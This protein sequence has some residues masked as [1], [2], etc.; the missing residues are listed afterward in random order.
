MNT[1][2]KS[3][4]AETVPQESFSSLH[5][6]ISRRVGNI[7]AATLDGRGMNSD[8]AIGMAKAIQE[9]IDYAFGKN[10]PRTMQGESH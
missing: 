6:D 5:G 10:A 1:N 3:V 2:P 8:R 9:S 7:R 4:F